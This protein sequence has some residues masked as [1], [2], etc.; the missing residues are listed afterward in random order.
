MSRYVDCVSVCAHMLVCMCMQRYVDVVFAFIYLRA[1]GRVYLKLRRSR[2]YLCV[3]ACECVN[4]WVCYVYERVFMCRGVSDYVH[5]VTVCAY[6]LLSG[7]TCS[8]AGCSVLIRT[9]L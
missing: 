4:V 2:V 7:W 6:G 3:R 9:S 8:V 1:C 5:M